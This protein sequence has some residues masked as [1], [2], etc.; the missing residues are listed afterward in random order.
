MP[1]NLEIPEGSRLRLVSNNNL[2]L[3]RMKRAVDVAKSRFRPSAITFL[4]RAL[5]DRADLDDLTINI[6]EEDLRDIG[7][8]ENLIKEYLKDYEAP[9]DLL[10]KVYEL[11]SK[12]N[13][14]VEENEEISRNVNWKLK[15]L[16]WDNL[17]N[18]GEGNYIDFE[19]LVGTVGIFGKNYSGKSSVIDSILYTVF[20]S[21]SKNERKN[22][23]VINQNKEYGQGEAKIEIDNKIY[24]ITRQSEKYV[25]K[26]KGQE[27]QEAK[28]DLDFKVYD[29][30][31]DIETDLNGVSR[32]DT[33][34]HIR[35]IFGT[36]EDFLITSM[37]SQL[38]ALQF[39]KE[40]STK[41]KEILAKLLD[42]EIFERKY[43]M[44]KDDAADLRGAL[45]RLEGEEFDE[46]I[47]IAAVALRENELAT[48]EQRYA[49]EQMAAALQLFENHLQETEKMIESIPT[50]IIDIVV[51]KEKLLNKQHEIR[52]LKNTNESLASLLGENRGNLEKVEQFVEEFDI[53]ALKESREKAKELREK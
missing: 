48:D 38:G 8:Q 51:I 42:L 37:T 41:R 17:F 53:E 49:C 28:T 25:K 24:T 44:A 34:R 26:L 20:N 43:K 6:G 31:L 7:V 22:L 18:Y 19:K 2:P 46:K 50:E 13:K 39:I 11:N 15:S 10:G 21:T 27:T 35:K 33:D 32:S 14:I 1:K 52:S 16:E 12:Y 40:G 9:D 47:E 23:N 45:R 4:N 30:V 3:N 5:G 29:P 36:L